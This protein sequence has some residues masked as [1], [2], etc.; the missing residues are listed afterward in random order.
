MA[1][2]QVLAGSHDE[3][4][5]KL[6]AI[7]ASAERR[8]QAFS[9]VRRQIDSSTISETSPDGGVRVSVQASGALR[10]L[11]LN[12]RVSG[13]PPAQLAALVMATVR[14]AQ[15]RIVE[16]VQQI[17]Q[18][19][20]VAD[21]PASVTMVERFAEQFPASEQDSSEAGQ[22]SLGTLEDDEPKR[23]PAPKPPAP[24]GGDEDWGDQS[25]LRKN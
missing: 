14:R 7:A 3:I 23:A 1:D 13:L 24:P 17:A 9:A 22:L 5:R 8:A 10:D 6:S 20:D 25:F 4:K 15:G 11:Q 16:R 21:D 19:N 18:D 2:E 12:E